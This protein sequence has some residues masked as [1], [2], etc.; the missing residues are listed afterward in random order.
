MSILHEIDGFSRLIQFYARKIGDPDSEN[1]LRNFLYIV[2]RERGCMKP[3]NYYAVCIRNEFIRLSKKR[4][5]F[6]ELSD[7]LTPQNFQ[8]EKIELKNALDN[9]DPKDALIIRLIFFGGY[10]VNEVSEILKI[11]RQAVSKRKRRALMKLGQ[12]LSI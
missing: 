11:S 5:I 6:D 8:F 7:D 3:Q 2:M 1:D 9:I 4:V 12:L 10:Q